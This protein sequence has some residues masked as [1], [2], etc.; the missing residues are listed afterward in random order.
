MFM[1]VKA[2]NG[3]SLALRVLL[4]LA[5]FALLYGCTQ[6]SSPPERQEKKGSGEQT[7]NEHAKEPKQEIEKE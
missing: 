2:I 6:A 4:V 1:I 3:G 5:A 7:G